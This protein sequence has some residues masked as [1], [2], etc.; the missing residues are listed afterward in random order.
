VPASHSSVLRCREQSNRAAGYRA[1]L[2]VTA[3]RARARHA[4][5]GK[6]SRCPPS[7]RLARDSLRSRLTTRAK[8]GGKG[9]RTPGL[10]IANET[11]YQLSYTPAKGREYH[12]RRIIHQ[13][14]V[15][16]EFSKRSGD[17]LE[18]LFRRRWESAKIFPW[19]REHLDLLRV[20]NDLDA[21]LDVPR[22]GVG[23]PGTELVS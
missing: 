13:G 12:A 18:R 2:Y 14:L 23:V 20:L 1:T 17:W 10:L 11:L 15:I 22:D 7:P 16:C 19:W 9:I 21:V 5:P 4:R 8:T 3:A 6:S